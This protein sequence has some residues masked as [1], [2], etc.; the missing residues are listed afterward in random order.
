VRAWKYRERRTTASGSDCLGFGGGGAAGLAA[1]GV[2]CCGGSKR[3]WGEEGGVL[4][5]AAVAVAW[6]VS[7]PENRVGWNGKVGGGQGRLSTLSEVMPPR[8]RSAEPRWWRL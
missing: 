1:G 6:R 2:A 3:L 5:L 8:S 4:K 7:C